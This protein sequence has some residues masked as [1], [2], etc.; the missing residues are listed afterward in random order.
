V[1]DT[2]YWNNGDRPRVFLNWRSFTDQ[3]IPDTWQA[4]VADAVM[5]AIT[6]WMMIAGV[7]C[8]PQF[9]NYTDRTTAEDG[10]V[11]VMMN[12]RHFD[13]TRLASTFTGWRK[14]TIVIHRKNGSTMTLWPWVPHNAQPGEIDMQAVLTHEFG[15]TFWLEDVTDADRT[16]NGGY[17]YQ[18]QR[19]GPFDGDVTAVKALYRDMDRNR[20]R[21]FR[22]TD[23]GGSWVV[24]N[25]QLTSHPRY[26]TRTTLTPGTSPI[27]SSGRHVI[28]WSM[29]NRVP[30]WLRTDGVNVFFDGWVAYF[31]ERSVHGPAFATAPDGTLLWAWVHNDRNG[32]IRVVRST[33]KAANWQWVSSPAAA[34]TAGTP[35]LACTTV[36]G[37]RAWVLAWSHLDRSIHAT[38]GD[39]H[40]SVSF[41][42]GASWSPAVSI[43]SYSAPSGPFAYK[44]LAG[45]SAAAAQDNRIMLAISWAGP[46]EGSMNLIRT[47]SCAVDQG[48]LV[49][50]S[51]G[52]S[53]DRTRVQ[54]ALAYHPPHDRFVL[55]FREQNFLTSLRVT[56]KAWDQQDWP[57]AQQLPSSTSQTG[58]ALG[59]GPVLQDLLLWYG[60]E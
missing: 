23:G 27:G 9:W 25:N 19:F 12:E 50:R 57:A 45:V 21:E 30:T 52:Y 32:S 56:S 5:N 15:H 41:D 58:P 31:G 47:F 10:E 2:A 6:R 59:F 53:G 18:R 46:S 24:Q 60:A 49:A 20:V 26:E 11:L 1:A 22:S 39:I 16:M 38:S 35:G 3:G 7:D 17:D 37:R 13:S 29:P 8:R 42:D 51:I 55:C 40:A 28:G 36:G 33:D 34:Q 43:G 14:A 48:N 54:P 4:A 44:C